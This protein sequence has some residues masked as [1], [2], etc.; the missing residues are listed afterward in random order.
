MGRTTDD[1]FEVINGQLVLKDGHKYTVPMRALDSLQRDV[2]RHFGDRAELQDGQRIV[3]GFDNAGLS[4]HRPGHRLFASGQGD[5]SFYDAY[6]RDISTRYLDA[7][8]TAG[9][10]GAGERGQSSARA[11]G[12]EEKIGQA[13]TCRG[14]RDIG[15]Q[16]SRGHWD[17]DEAGRVVCIADDRRRGDDGLDVRDHQQ[18]MADLRAELDRELSNAWRN[19]PTR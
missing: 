1:D 2:A 17:Y 19:P 18:R 9:V 13:C 16:G 6:D 14:G 5:Q 12:D 10:E 11:G 4:L 3:D 15:V 8:H 7:D